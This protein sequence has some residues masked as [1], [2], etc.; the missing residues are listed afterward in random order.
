MQMGAF[1]DDT[2]CDSAFNLKKKNYGKV[3]TMKN[4]TASFVSSFSD[5]YGIDAFNVVS[6]V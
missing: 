2:V 1:C 6:K 3:E 5:F 4:L